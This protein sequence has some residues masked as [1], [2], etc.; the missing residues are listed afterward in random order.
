MIE[1]KFLTLVEINL[2]IQG[3]LSFKKD[4]EFW[5]VAFTEEIFKSETFFAAIATIY[6]DDGATLN[7]SIKED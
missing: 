1:V 3:T 7:M 4:N 5:G 6:K 2:S